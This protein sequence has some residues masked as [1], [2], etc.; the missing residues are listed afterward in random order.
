MRIDGISDAEVIQGSL[1]MTR[2]KALERGA[3]FH[4]AI[5]QM[6]GERTEILQ[7]PISGISYS[8]MRNPA[9]NNDERMSGGNFISC[10]TADSLWRMDALRTQVAEDAPLVEQALADCLEQ[11]GIDSHRDFSMTVAYDEDGESCIHVGREHPQW[12]AI[13]SLFHNNAA[14]HSDVM[15]L[16]NQ[17]SVLADM[18]V[19][20]GILQENASTGQEGITKAWLAHGRADLL[21]SRQKASALRYHDGKLGFLSHQQQ[22]LSIA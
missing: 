2:K 8:I 16:W 7:R 4:E 10:P 13:E 21:S 17:Q 6:T 3:S 18:E 11:A 12:Q 15:G 19:V 14:L 22:S 20:A 1:I 9:A 5:I